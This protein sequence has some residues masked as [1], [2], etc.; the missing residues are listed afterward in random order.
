M[1]TYER[2]PRGK[3]KP[4]DEFKDSTMRVFEWL[5][6]NWQTSVEVLAVILVAVSVIAG[7]SVYWN[8]RSETAAEKLY[9][10][11]MVDAGSE[12]QINQLAEIIDGY[13]RTP[14]GQQAM[15]KLG[16]IY[17]DKNEFDKASEVFKK[18]TGRSR[19]RP[20]FMI[21]AL[22]KLARAELKEGKF[23][24]AAETYLKAASDPHNL[25]SIDSRFRAAAAYEQANDL[26]K[27]EGLYNQIVKE[28]KDSDGSIRDL[29]EERLIWLALNKKITE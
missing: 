14:S 11:L 9:L 29:S 24:L 10:V 5:R 21:A 28:A 1:S 20:L 22:H 12:N 13:S 3:N 25:I 6:D 16:D 23:A 15:L 27:A 8:H 2:L 7:A 26:E 18:L 19:N 4:T 17:L